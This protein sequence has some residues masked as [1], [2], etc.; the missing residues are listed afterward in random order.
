MKYCEYCG[1]PLNAYNCCDNCVED[2][3]DDFLDIHPHH[4]P[5][6][7]SNPFAVTTWDDDDNYDFDN[8]H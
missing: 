8:N 7:L 6:L 2:E 1:N 5:Y 3:D 4:M